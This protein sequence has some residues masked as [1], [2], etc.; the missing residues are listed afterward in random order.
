MNIPLFQRKELAKQKYNKIIKERNN[1]KKIE[2]TENFMEEYLSIIELLLLNNTDKDIV[3]LYLNFIKE[4]DLYVKS[5]NF[6]TFDDE[7]KVYKLVLTIEEVEN[8]KKGIKL[9]SEKD[10]LL[11]FL[12]ELSNIVND[13]G[14]ANDDDIDTIFAKVDRESKQIIY[15]N[16]PI[17][18]SNKELYFYKIYILLILHISKVNEKSSKQEKKNYLINKSGVAKIILNKYS[19]SL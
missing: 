11:N 9:Q 5:Y 17:E 18:F 4:N 6:E 8:F 15:F 19:I 2:K 12:A 10:V 16:Y 3:S 1:K 14:V 13:D 7:I